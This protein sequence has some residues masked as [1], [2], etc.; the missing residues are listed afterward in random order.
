MKGLEE[1]NKL[2]DEPKMFWYP[3]V[4]GCVVVVA[5]IAGEVVGGMMV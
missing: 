3:V 2:T 1:L 4:I 5:F